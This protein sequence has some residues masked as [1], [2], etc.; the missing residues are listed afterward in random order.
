VTVQR[1]A[2]LIGAK[3]RLTMT[4]YVTTITTY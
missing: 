4:L 3:K 1:T 2:G